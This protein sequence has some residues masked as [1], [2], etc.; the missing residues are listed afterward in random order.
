MG[1]Q[2]DSSALEDLCLNVL[3]MV[4]LV[5]LVFVCLDLRM[6]GVKCVNQE[7]KGRGTRGF[8]ISEI[9]GSKWVS[10]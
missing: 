1:M 7:R 3:P 6:V 2:V 10:K 5:V 9:K 4:V 8:K